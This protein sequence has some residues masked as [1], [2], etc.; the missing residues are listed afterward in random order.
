M[1]LENNNFKDDYCDD[2]N[3]NAGCH[4][5]GG[6]CCNKKVTGWNNFCS[7]CECKDSG[8]SSEKCKNDWRFLKLKNSNGKVT[9]S[10]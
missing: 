7:D 10:R 4:Y 6:A 5:D 8:T 1:I 2:D 3:N 9:K